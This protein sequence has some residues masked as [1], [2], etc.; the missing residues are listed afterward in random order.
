MY[1][2]LPLYS[3]V[4][5]F[6]AMVVVPSMSTA[7]VDIDVATNSFTAWFKG[8]WD[9]FDNSSSITNLMDEAMTNIE[10]EWY[11]KAQCYG[12]LPASFHGTL[13]S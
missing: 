6:L 11:A 7:P 12:P 13:F 4:I 10:Q 8:E 3:H 9:G 2:H 5:L 1:F